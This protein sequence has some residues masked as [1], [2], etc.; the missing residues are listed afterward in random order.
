[1]KNADTFILPDGLGTITLP[2][3]LSDVETANEDN[4]DLPCIPPP[5]PFASSEG[6]M[7]ASETNDQE[8]EMEQS[9]LQT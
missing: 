1:M 5:S 8:L 3:P 4:I 7:D 9:I 6:T 2:P